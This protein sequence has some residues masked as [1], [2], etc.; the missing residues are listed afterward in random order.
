MEEQ[1]TVLDSLRC[2]Y[3]STDSATK[4]PSPSMFRLETDID[5]LFQID[6]MIEVIIRNREVQKK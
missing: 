4:I 3:V 6:L 5:D 1:Y 2:L